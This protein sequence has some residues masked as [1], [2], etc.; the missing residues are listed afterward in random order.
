MSRF[1]YAITT[2]LI[3]LSAIVFS[4][5]HHAPRWMWNGSASAPIGLYALRS[6]LPIQ[7]GDLVAVRPPAVLARYMAARGYLPDNVAMLK[8]VA[9]VRAQIVCRHDAVVTIDGRAVAATLNKDHAG[10]L[11]PVWHGCHT[12]GPDEIFLLNALRTDS[13]D[14]RYF[15]VLSLESITARAEPLWTE[16]RALLVLMAGSAQ[17]AKPAS[18]QQAT[19]SAAVAEASVRFGTTADWIRA[20]IMVES[21]ADPSAVSPKGAIGLMQIMPTTW[22]DLRRSFGLGPDPFDVHDNVI[23]GTAYLRELYERFGVAGFLAA[24]NAGPSR[25]QALLSA[26]KPLSQE[27]RLYLTKLAPLLGGSLGQAVLTPVRSQAWGSAPL[28]F[29]PESTPAGLTPADSS[30]AAGMPP[31]PSFTRLAPSSAGL[32]ATMTIAP[33]P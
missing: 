9:A 10:R 1:G 26:G 13:F 17:A 19:I 24:Y 7:L 28:F 25:Y 18:A 32:F 29:R 8:F 21:G 14:G 12:L 11:L 23:A 16:P 20:V 4:L 31:R 15:G 2:Y 22:T 3:T 5:F 33:S 27:T 6:P 30:S